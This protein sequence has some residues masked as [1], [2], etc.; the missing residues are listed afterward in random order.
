MNH[1]LSWSLKSWCTAS[2]Y[3]HSFSSICWMQN[4]WL[5]VD[6]LCQNPHWW[7]PII[8]SAFRF[9]LD[10]SMLDKILYVVGKSDMSLWLLHAILSRFIYSYIVTTINSF[11]CSGNSS[12]FQIELISLWISDWI[13]LHPVLINSAGIWS[14]HDDLYSN[15]MIFNYTCKLK[16]WK[17]KADRGDRYTCEHTELGMVV[18]LDE[19]FAKMWEHHY[20]KPGKQCKVFANWSNSDLHELN[21]HCKSCIK[22]RKMSLMFC[23][24][25]IVVR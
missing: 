18:V 13:I 4:I 25:C 11:N 16:F 21:W 5:V 20:I 19:A 24:L 8:S 9:N 1:R 17:W 14:V 2:L 6:L 7:S 22:V 15:I 3:S 12:L 23:G 10:S